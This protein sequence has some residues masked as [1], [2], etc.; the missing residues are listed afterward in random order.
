MQWSA[1]GWNGGWCGEGGEGDEKLKGLRD[2]G[3]SLNIDM[4]TGKL[5]E[6]NLAKMLRDN[7]IMSSFSR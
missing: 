7:L 2:V 6:I 1:S 3:M 5:N 4:I